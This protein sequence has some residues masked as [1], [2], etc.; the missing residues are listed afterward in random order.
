MRRVLALVCCVAV[1][2]TAGCALPGGVEVGGR[3]SQVTPPPSTPPLP[4]G[5]PVSADPVAVLR[6]DPQIPDKLKSTLV[7]CEDGTYPVIDRYADL[8]GD[9]TAELV[10]TLLGCPYDKPAVEASGVRYAFGYGFA[11][12]A[13]DLATEPPTRLFGVEDGAL[14]LVPVQEYGRVLLL[15]RARWAPKDDPCCPSDQSIVL[16]RWDGTQFV[17]EP[18]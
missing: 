18:R 14:E 6:A 16:Y 10:V 11:G 9:G 17:E 3:A 8:T 4:S 2:G 7:P 12:Y 15:S 13:Y 5:T 1:F